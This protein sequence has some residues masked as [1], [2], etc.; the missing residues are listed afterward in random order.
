MLSNTEKDLLKM[1]CVDLKGSLILTKEREYEVIKLA[2]QGNKE[3]FHCLVI[4]NLKFVLKLAFK[5]Y[6]P[7]LSLMD[8]IS[9]G[10]IGLIIAFKTFDPDREVKFITYAGLSITHRIFSFIKWH[11][12]HEHDS[13][14]EP[15]FNDGSDDK[16]LKD[17]LVSNDTPADKKVFYAQIRKLLNQL[18]RRE[19]TVIKSRYWHDLTLEE[20]GLEIGLKKESVRRIENRALRTLRWTLYK[21]RDSLGLKNNYVMA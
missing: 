15:K 4:S 10:C 5:F 7:G 6:S 12:K 16:T 20:T 9:E 11:R 19:Q 3:A 2:K 8:L 14:D 17:Y 1:F 13:L 21:E 18:N